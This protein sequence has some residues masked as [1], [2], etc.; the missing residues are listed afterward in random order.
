MCTSR[1][2][3]ELS[4]RFNYTRYLYRRDLIAAIGRFTPPGVRGLPFSFPCFPACQ[5][6]QSPMNVSRRDRVQDSTIGSYKVDLGIS[7]SD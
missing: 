4:H 7:V 1:L 6:F 3:A 2:V 5:L